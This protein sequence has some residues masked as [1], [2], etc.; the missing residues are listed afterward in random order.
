M[1]M[2][3]LIVITDIIVTTG[4]QIISDLISQY[5]REDDIDEYRSN[6]DPDDIVLS[7]TKVIASLK[8]LKKFLT[9]H[10]NKK[11]NKYCKSF[12]VLKLVVH[13]NLHLK[14]KSNKK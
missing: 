3:T 6:E 1:L 14:R 8:N 7:S 10:E 9:G 5:E 2:R 4:I 11:I 12:H 13:V